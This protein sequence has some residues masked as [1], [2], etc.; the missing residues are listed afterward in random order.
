MEW[1]RG[2]VIGKGSF[3]SVYLATPRKNYC[4]FPPLMAVKS[5]LASQSSLLQKEKEILTEFKDCPQILNCY[6]DGFTVENDGD[7]LYNL[8]L[9]FA[10]GGN[11]AQLLKN[12]GGSISESH[13]R[14]Y[15][16]SILQGL[17]SIHQ[18]GFVH[19]DMKLQNILLCCSANGF[20]ELKIADFGLAKKSDTNSEKDEEV[21][22]LRG[23]P[24]YMSPESVSRNEI[25]SASD[26]WALGC[27]ISEMIT[28]K[29]AWGFN[30][31]S[32]I[33]ALLYR[34]GFKDEL[35]E[36]PNGISEDGKD[37]L[38]RCFVRDP[39]KRWT[40]EMLLNHP[41]IAGADTVSLPIQTQ[42]DSPTSAFGFPE[43]NCGNSSIFNSTESSSDYQFDHQSSW[44]LSPSERIAQ[45]A[46]G[47][48]SN[49]SFSDSWINVRRRE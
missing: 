32:D 45:I 21:P 7:R 17:L 3:S 26:I 49:W 18:K 10:S 35:P 24:L 23:T 8:F 37:F 16:K 43:W 9:E 19:C 25:E 39:L 38:R 29:P 48:G 2:E 33:S 11:L 40:A 12:S 15:S 5:S 30:E 22:G 34:I 13:V 41:F 42:K 31:N 14:F 36:I 1:D 27:I 4:D 20:S 47:N 44:S 6:G 46:T 28:G